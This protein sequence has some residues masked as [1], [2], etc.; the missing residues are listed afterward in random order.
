MLKDKR[1]AWLPEEAAFESTGVG[2]PNQ[3]PNVI[4]ILA[5]DLGW[6]DVGCY[7]ALQNLTPAIDSLAADGLRFNHGYSGSATCSPTR[8]SL[9]TGRYPGRT[10]AGLAEPIIIADDKT[11]LPPSSQHFR[12]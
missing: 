5:D 11:G 9:Y 12:L 1:Q 8:V 6:G 2:K 3:A 7:G 10:Y 4:F